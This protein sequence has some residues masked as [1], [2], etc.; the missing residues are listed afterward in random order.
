MPSRASFVK[1]A[2]Y[3]RDLPTENILAEK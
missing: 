3:P 2:G 1:K